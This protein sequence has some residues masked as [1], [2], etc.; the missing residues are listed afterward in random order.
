MNHW[1]IGILLVIL[2]VF[3]LLAGCNGLSPTTDGKN[4]PM[5]VAVPTTV[6]PISNPTPA[7]PAQPA[8]TNVTIPPTAAP[9]GKFLIF[10]P[11]TKGEQW[12]FVTGFHDEGA[13]DFVNV[14]AK[15]VA[16]I[17]VAD[18][19]VLFSDYSHPDDFNTYKRDRPGSTIPDMGNF[20]ILKHGPDIYT[21]YMHFLHEDPAPVT[22]GQAVRA[23]TRIGWQGNTGWSHGAH[24]HFAVVDVQIFPSPSF[25]E[26][27]KESWGFI[28]LNGSNAVVLNARY[29]SQNAVTPSPV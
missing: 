28:E 21:V 18:G 29:I 27:P 22:P 10:F 9:P 14:N 19:T 3:S 16:V 26:K 24:L 23:G 12:E 13:M 7:L 2:A 11:W 4:L 5:T 15:K 20:V 6:I 8:T 25:I 17:A 1:G